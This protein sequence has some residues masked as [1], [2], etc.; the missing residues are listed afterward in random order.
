MRWFQSKRFWSTALI[1]FVLFFNIQAGID[2][3]LFPQHYTYAY[4]LIGTPGEV[5]IAGFGILFLMWNVP[6]FFAIW[7]PTRQRLSLIQAVIMQAIG[8]IGESIILTRIPSLEHM[9]LRSSIWRFIIFDSAG[10][11]LL[12]LALVIILLDK[13]RLNKK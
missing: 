4:E 13:T 1:G 12:I 5:A 8:V 9:L 11:L 10:L 3:F 2:F 6:Y 7:N